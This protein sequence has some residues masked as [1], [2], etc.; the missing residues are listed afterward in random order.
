MGKFRHIWLNDKY[1]YFNTGNK[2]WLRGLNTCEAVV[3]HQ[4]IFRIVGD[5]FTLKTADI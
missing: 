1:V 2:S 5:C 4:N 3:C